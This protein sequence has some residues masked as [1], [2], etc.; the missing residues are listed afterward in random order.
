MKKE[1]ESFA[2]KAKALAFACALL[3][4]GLCGCGPAGPGGS[5]IQ[6]TVVMVPPSEVFPAYAGEVQ[7]TVLS[8]NP[9]CRILSASLP[10][11]R[12]MVERSFELD[13]LVRAYPPGTT[14]LVFGNAAPGREGLAIVVKTKAGRILVGPDSGVFTRTLE[15]EEIEAFRH[16]A[17][18][19]A[20]LREGL[21]SMFPERDVYA[22][23]AAEILKG[24][25]LA[26]LGAAGAAPVRVPI[27][28]ATGSGAA[29]SGEVLFINWTGR[30]VTSF[31][32]ESFEKVRAGDLIRLNSGG[33][34]FTVPYLL[35][36]NEAPP[37]RPFGVCN[38]DGFFEIAVLDANAAQVLKLIPGQK[39]SI[40]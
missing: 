35:D 21:N 38:A 34:P 17:A 30:V 19:K 10:S 11:N 20:L 1:S 40:R 36:E 12:S 15:R 31:R 16:V 24:V 23:V 8:A 25:P 37:G 22:P 7:G 14:F 2:G 28:R 18:S 9:S 3:L 32:V 13:Q 39:I 4:S 33:K 29:L 6:N 5:S 27:P 26:D